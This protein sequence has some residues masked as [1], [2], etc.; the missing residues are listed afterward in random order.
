MSRCVQEEEV[1]GTVDIQHAWNHRLN[2]GGTMS[3]SKNKNNILVD[4]GGSRKLLLL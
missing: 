1:V 3:K 4:C 2:K